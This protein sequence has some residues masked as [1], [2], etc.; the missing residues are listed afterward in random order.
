MLVKQGSQRW[1]S[2]E[3][4]ELRSFFTRRRVLTAINMMNSAPLSIRSNGLPQWE[5]E[6][7]LWSNQ[8]SVGVTI[9]RTLKWLKRRRG[10]VPRTRE[11]T[12][13]VIER[14]VLVMCDVWCLVFYCFDLILIQLSVWRTVRVWSN[15]SNTRTSVWSCFQTPKNES[16]KT[17]RSRVF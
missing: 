17:R 4:P 15:I 16:L 12:W 13:K 11:T 9:C 6:L 10:S 1:C 8:N 14:P 2:M 5:R 3:S 7:S